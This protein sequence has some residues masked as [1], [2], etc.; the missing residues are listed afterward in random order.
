MEVEWIGFRFRMSEGDETELTSE[1]DSQANDPG[2][3]F[4]TVGTG[5]FFAIGCTVL[6]LIVVIFG[7]AMFILRQTG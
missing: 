4:E 7:V 1:G 3:D 6:T 5:S 2:A